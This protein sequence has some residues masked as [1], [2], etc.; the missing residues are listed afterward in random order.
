MVCVWLFNTS[1]DERGLLFF[2]SWACG[3]QK[4]RRRG[5]VGFAF[6]EARVSDASTGGNWLKF[7]THKYLVALAQLHDVDIYGAPHQARSYLHARDAPAGG[8]RAGALR[9]P[10][11][12]G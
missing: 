6:R 12:R 4:N 10:Q 9:C 8:G 1:R 3:R 5:L 2:P 7:A 11:E